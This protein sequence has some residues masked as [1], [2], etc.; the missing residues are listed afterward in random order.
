MDIAEVLGGI[1]LLIIGVLAVVPLPLDGWFIW[2]PPEPSVTA[3]V[4]VIAVFLMILGFC[5]IVT[6][7]R[8]EKNLR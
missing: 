3:L 6:G 8:S 1:F 4:I 7:F 5:L 2:F